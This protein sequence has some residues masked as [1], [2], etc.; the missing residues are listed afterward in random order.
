[1]HLKEQ[2]HCHCCLSAPEL[3]VEEARLLE[4]IG[5][6]HIISYAEVKATL[7]SNT[8]AIPAIPYLCPQKKSLRCN[9]CPYVAALKDM[10]RYQ[11]KEHKELQQPCTGAYT[12]CQTQQLFS[13][14]PYLL[15]VIDPAAETASTVTAAPSPSVTRGH[16]EVMLSTAYEQF[17][18]EEQK[19]GSLVAQG[20]AEQETPF[21]RFL[22][23]SSYLRP[24]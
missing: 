22:Q 8:A 12:S 1:M 7:A 23:L 20:N 17:C 19:A 14:K 3:E 13:S 10:Q 4:V 21:M 16:W 5:P 18:T 11:K 6:L 9:F 2:G 24:D 15:V